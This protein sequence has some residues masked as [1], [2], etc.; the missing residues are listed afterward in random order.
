M[1]LRSGEITADNATF[2]HDLI[3]RH[4]EYALK[5]SSGIARFEIRPNPRFPGNTFWI[6]RI[7]GSETDFSFLRCIKGIPLTHRERVI[8][9]MRGHVLAQILDYKKENLAADTK[10]AL[11]GAP[12][13]DEDGH[14]DHVV[15]FIDMVHAFLENVP[16]ETIELMPPGDGKFGEQF[17]DFRLIAQWQEF[18]RKRAQLQLC[19]AQANMSKGSKKLNP[20]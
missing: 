14:V 13:A 8:A 11:T 9:A 3:R 15:P 7:D 17:A 18:H 12:L 4:P 5:A 16:I 1:I 6:I 20:R 19:T 10:C 2:L